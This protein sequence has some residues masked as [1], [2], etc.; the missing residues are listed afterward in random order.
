MF[1]HDKCQILPVLIVCKYIVL[2][3][4]RSVIDTK[5]VDAIIMKSFFKCV[6]FWFVV[7]DVLELNHRNSLVN[8]H[9]SKQ[10]WN[11]DCICVEMSEK[12]RHI[13]LRSTF[14]TVS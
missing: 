8:V 9:Q 1:L 7:K 5:S 14:L 12:H 2:G 3:R 11:F 4:Y 6:Y 10:V 13:Q